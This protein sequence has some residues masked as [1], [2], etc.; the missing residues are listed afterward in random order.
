MRELICS[1]L[2]VST[3]NQRD[4][5]TIETQRYALD[6]YCELYGIQVDRRFE[7]DGVS[8][9]IEIHKRPKG[10]ELYKLISAG[11]VKC[12]LLFHA[13]RIGRDTID[14]LLFHRLAESQG[15]RIIGTA[16]GTDT[17]REGSVFTTEMRAVVAAELRR[18][19]TRRTKNGLRR[20]AR[21]G[22]I[23][24]HAPFGYLIEDGRL[25]IDESKAEI[26]AQV[27]AKVVLGERTGDIV[28]WLNESNAPSPRG[29]GWRH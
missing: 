22:K 17:A 8:G 13:D 25:V 14:S 19:C 15:T 12:L 18:D 1:Y 4:E 9:G 3:A 6:R 29:K 10:S 7:D 16:D 21:E 26:V 28:K 11:S 24:T 5:Q 20:R 2:R 27:F 23:S